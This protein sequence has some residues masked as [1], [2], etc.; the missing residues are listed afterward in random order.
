[1]AL[2]TLYSGRVKGAHHAGQSVLVTG[3][4]MIGGV[5][6][7]TIERHIGF[8]N[9]V[10][11]PFSGQ[12]VILVA[13]CSDEIAITVEIEGF[14]TVAADYIRYIIPFLTCG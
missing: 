1:M 7:S 12:V 10:I 9:T 13:G 8:A 5:A 2:F 11:A 14:R 3:L 4:G 6:G